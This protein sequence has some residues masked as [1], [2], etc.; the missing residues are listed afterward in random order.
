MRVTP[1]SAASPV[2]VYNKHINEMTDRDT[3]G[4]TMQQSIYNSIIHDSIT[5]QATKTDTG[6]TA[7]AFWGASLLQRLA[8]R[9]D[10]VGVL[11]LMGSSAAY[12]VFALAHL[13][14]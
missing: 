7:P 8:R 11:A 14:L 4:T 2:R 3:G 6:T 5:I 9:W 12:G 1:A 10:M 13:G